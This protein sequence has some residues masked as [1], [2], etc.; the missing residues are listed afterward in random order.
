M[1]TM[2]QKTV[3]SDVDWVLTSDRTGPTRTA[4]A[5][6]R[7][8]GIVA[9]FAFVETGEGVID[10]VAVQAS[11]ATSQK[12]ADAT[13]RQFAKKIANDPAPPRGM[14]AVD[15]R[16][17]SH[18]PL[19]SRVRRE[20]R[21]HRQGLAARN[22]FGTESSVA[23]GKIRRSDAQVRLAEFAVAY[24]QLSAEVEGSVAAVFAERDGVSVS[25]IRERVQRAKDAGMYRTT[26][27]GRRGEATEKAHQIVQEQKGLS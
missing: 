23:A 11:S 2:S 25:A 9:C 5:Y 7:T 16:I 24:E 27:R 8:G 18:G 3:I 15:V 22:W 20:L 10:L 12:A 21:S 14:R 19:L 17:L 6:N 1:A 26:G 13:A 4:V